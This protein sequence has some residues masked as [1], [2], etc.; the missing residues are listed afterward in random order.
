MALKV[1]LT[2]RAREGRVFV[3]DSF[4][5]SQPNTQQAR[6]LLG[7]IIPEKGRKLVVTDGNHHATVRS[8]T[9]LP[10]VMADRA[11]SLHAYEVLKSSYVLLTSEALSK[12]EEVFS[13]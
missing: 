13:K 3:I 7:K 1:A 5:F 11:D 6:E 12:V 4:D 9:N 2:D 8:F 10:D